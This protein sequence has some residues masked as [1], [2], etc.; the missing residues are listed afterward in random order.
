MVLRKQFQIHPGLAVKA[1]DKGLRHQIAQIFVALPVLAQ[2]HQMV[3][4][5]VQSVNLVR[6]PASGN[7]DLAADDGLDPGGLGGLVKIDTAVHD[8]VVGDGDGGLAQLLHPVHQ[9][10]DAAGPVQQA[11][12][13]M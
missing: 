3:G 1:V 2:Q 8:A 5:V 12:L 4:V 9:V 10:I 13:T 11:I 6:H 7:V